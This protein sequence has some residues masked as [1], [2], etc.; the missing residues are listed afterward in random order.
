MLIVIKSTTKPMAGNHPVTFTSAYGQGQAEWYGAP[1]TV[2]RE[3][4]VE[5]EIPQ[6]LTWGKEITPESKTRPTIGVTEDGY[7]YIIGFL[8]QVEEDGCLTIR[9]GSS[10]VLIEATGTAII[11]G[12][13]VRVRFERLVLYDTGL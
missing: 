10:I 9:L 3:Y 11:G 13:Y 7:N 6:A 2:E 4:D 1:P 8:E 5:L 12:G